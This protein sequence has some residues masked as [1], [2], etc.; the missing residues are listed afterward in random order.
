MGLLF[1]IS[2]VPMTNFQ[3]KANFIWQVADDILRGSFKP[4]EYGDVTLPFVVL[5][6]LD[7]VLAP[8]RDEVRETYLKF[9]DVLD[10][11]TPV[12]LK[13]T[14][15]L[16]FYNTSQYDLERLGQDAKN[17]QLNVQTYINGFS[18]NVRD[19]LKNFQLGKHIAKLTKNK[20]LFMMV[21]RFTEVDVHP[22]HVSN[23]EMGYIY[24]ELLRRFSEM[25]N[26][27]A[28]DH[29]TPREVIQ[30]MVNLIF[31]QDK[32]TLTGRGIIRS[33]YDP[34]CGTGGMLTIAKD[35]ILETINEDIT[36]N[37]FGQELNEQTYAI[38]KSDFLI[39]GENPE[40]IRQG[41]SFT[42]DKFKGERFNY[43]LS[44]PPYGVSWKKEKAFVTH[45]AA[46]PHGRFKAGTP[47][48]SDGSLLFVQHMI[49]KMEPTGSRMGIVLNGSPLFTGDAGS[50]E[51]DIRKWI[52]ENDWLETIVALPTELFYNTG[53]ATY[54]WI[55]TNR[56]APERRGKVQLIDGTSFYKKMRKSLG[57]KRNYITD[58]QIDALTQLYAAFEAGP[59]VKV[60]DNADFGY[61]K[62]RVDRPERTK[63]GE[64]KFK[65]NGEPVADSALRDYERV[66]LTEDVNAYFE[67]EVIPHVPDAWID[68]SYSRVGYEI[69]FTQYFYEYKPLRSTEEIKRDILELDRETEGLLMKVL[70][71]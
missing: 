48:V 24:E 57:N 55:V 40:N 17:I 6:R 18:P 61:T 1:F 5:R 41:N 30:L 62:I 69:N 54:V 27:Q 56:K 58:E 34:A 53:I 3:D 44:N 20:L 45:E 16:N 50:G 13:A 49:S 8:S 22:D 26:E 35:H 64:P 7:C 37:L 39:T 60:F 59:H 65:R 10:D 19:I 21:K 68:E 66:P 12:V 28:G 38:S 14:G 70:E 9:K 36:V 47:R 29:Y 43:L 23:H 46:D 25:A 67:R 4:H 63:H 11:P 71:A 2:D 15:G 52:I 31:A 32:D 42:E 51:S 33:V